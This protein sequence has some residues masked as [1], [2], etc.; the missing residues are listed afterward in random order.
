MNTDPCTCSLCKRS[1]RITDA[2]TKGNAATLQSLL[3][4]LHPKLVEAELE[5]DV[6]KARLKSLGQN[7]KQ[8]GENIN[9]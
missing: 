2:I 4:E 6:L 3:K 5:R 8:I 1:Y 9:V 7:T